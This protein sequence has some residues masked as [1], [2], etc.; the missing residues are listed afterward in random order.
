MQPTRAHWLLVPLMLL[1]AACDATDPTPYP[2]MTQFV[3]PSDVPPRLLPIPPAKDSGEYK[4]EIDGI[5]ATQQKLTAEDK[6][7]IKAEDHITP[8]MMVL[9][10]IGAQYSEDK[11]P[12]M[13][14]LLRHAASD[15]WR[16]A[17][18]AQDYWNRQRPWM[19]DERVELL[20]NPITRPSY[21]SGHS[22]TNHVWAHVLSDLFP[23]KQD[24]LFARAYEIGMHR[25]AA[26]AHYPSD[27]EAGKRFAS[28]IFDKM[29]KTPQYKTELATA[30]A[31]INAAIL[32][33]GPVAVPVAATPP[34]AAVVV[35]ATPAPIPAAAIIPATPATPNTPLPQGSA[36][37]APQV[38]AP[39]A[40]VPKGNLPVDCMHP[41]PGELQTKCQ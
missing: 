29:S 6:A 34:A 41:Q 37:V 11:Y 10:V 13:Y 5:L 38:K 35:P 20:V 21:P 14:N 2:Y 31:E 22:S 9:P 28:F 26:G 33:A 18:Y 12:A 32:A 1:I 23:E 17:D 19:V 39:A 15:A 27:V 8:T 4:G 40:V 16:D 36:P 25:V 7:V 3:S 24:A 30:Q